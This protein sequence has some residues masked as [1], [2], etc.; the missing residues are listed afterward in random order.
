MISENK[1]S[2]NARAEKIFSHEIYFYKNNFF[3]KNNFS[4]K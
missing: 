1:F 3:A 4:E 2:A